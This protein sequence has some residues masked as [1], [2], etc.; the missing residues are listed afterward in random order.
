MPAQE[1]A[2][3][4]SR[5][6]EDELNTMVSAAERQSFSSGAIII[7]EGTEPGGLYVI[8]QGV[9]RLTKDADDKPQSEFAN[10]LGPGEIVGEISY[11]DGLSASATLVADGDVEVIRIDKSAIDQMIEADATFAERFYRSLLID[12][13][14]RLRAA[15]KRIQLPYV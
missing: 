11:V 14:S 13:V 9:L 3:A 10:P 12:A 7:Q 4:F 5:L 15:N 2:R 6:T 1:I 8:A